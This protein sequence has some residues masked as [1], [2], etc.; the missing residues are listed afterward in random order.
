LSSQDYPGA[1]QGFLAVL[2]LEPRNV[3]ALGNLGVVYSRMNR[4]G[5]AVQTYERALRIA[6]GNPALMLNLGLAYVKQEQFAQALPIFTKLGATAPTLQNRQLLATCLVET[7]QPEKALT[8]LDALVRENP[9]DTGLLYLQGVAL[10]RLKKSDAA[11]EAW[12]RM[13]AA[14]P[15]AQ[16]AFLMGKASYE[17]ENFEDAA[18]FF[19]QALEADPSLQDSHRELGK[20]LVSLRDNE[21]AAKELRLAD[22]NDGEAL[23]FLGGALASVA[24]PEAYPVLE[25]ARDL[26]PDFWG[27]YYYLGKLQFE[28][29][30][31]RE[32]LANLEHAVR[33]KPD[34]SAVIYQLGRAYQKAGRAA[35]AQAA[36]EKVRK[37]KASSLGKEVQAMSPGK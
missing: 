4:F 18:K 29:G 3:G 24:D 19:R 35:E 13:M 26:N 14:A 15:P 27:S 2:K 8:V 21:A 12:A 11:H 7:G 32:A 20:T 22:P 9:S 28:Q 17:T 6:P 34:E 25:K 37:L 1:E 10:A 23:Y 16:A 33:L 36:F 5:Q 30:K 31:T